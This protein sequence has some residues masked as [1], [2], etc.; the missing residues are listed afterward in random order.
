MWWI[1]ILFLNEVYVAINLPIL[2]DFLFFLGGG[3]GNNRAGG[4][5]GFCAFRIST[6]SQKQHY[7][8]CG[9][10]VFTRWRGEEGE[11]T[12]FS[13]EKKTNLFIFFFL[14]NLFSNPPI[15]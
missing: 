2:A 3:K 13:L 6:V 15:T 9:E 8:F 10:V 1:T 14:A 7:I 12:K 5:T 11:L 4:E